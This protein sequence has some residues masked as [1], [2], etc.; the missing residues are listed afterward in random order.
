MLFNIPFSRDIKE[1]QRNL[2]K[3]IHSYLN[4]S[5]NPFLDIVH[6]YEHYHVH[7]DKIAYL[8]KCQRVTEVHTTDG[9][10]YRSYR[11]MYKYQELLQESMFFR[12]SQGAIVNWHFLKHV[13]GYRA[14]VS[15]GKGDKAKT[16]DLPVSPKVYKF[17]KGEL[18][19]RSSITG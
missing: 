9:E 10:V 12:I 13:K 8:E 18:A 5:F 7:I 4:I 17:V 11:P 19:L 14:I 1:V 16:V 6:E 2:E 3:L 15:Y